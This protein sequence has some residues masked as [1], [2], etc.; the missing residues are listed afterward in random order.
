[1]LQEEK[2]IIAQ[3][4]IPDETTGTTQVRGLL[5][6]VDLENAVVTA[7]VVSAQRDTAEHIARPEEDCGR[8]SAQH[9]PNPSGQPVSHTNDRG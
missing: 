2:V 1:M 6:P 7:D 5:D 8:T 9:Q 3:H 4:R